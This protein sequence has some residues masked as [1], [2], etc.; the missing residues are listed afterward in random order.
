MRR[1]LA[2][3]G[4]ALAAPFLLVVRFY[5]RFVSPYTPP[6]CRFTPSCSAY[7][8]EALR[9]LPVHRALALTLWRLLRCQPL[10][11]GGYDP[12]P[13]RAT[14]PPDPPSDETAGH[15][16]SSEDPRRPR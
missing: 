12:V 14:P 16:S 4:A 1:A 6:T 13:A 10:C 8:E 7:A 5:R 11:R 15:R 3:L 9:T 2:L